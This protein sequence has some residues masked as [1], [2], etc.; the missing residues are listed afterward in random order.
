MV[1]G[2]V[3]NSFVQAGSCDQGN[4]HAVSIKGGEILIRR[5]TIRLSHSLCSVT[6]ASLHSTCIFSCCFRHLHFKRQ[7]SG[8]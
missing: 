7:L 8:L 1:W 5:A 6:A 2:Y 3:L 4:E